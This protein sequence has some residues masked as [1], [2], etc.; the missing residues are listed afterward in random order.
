M[1]DLAC[2]V[3]LVWLEVW[4]QRE[5]VPFAAS[6]GTIYHVT[7]IIAQFRPEPIPSNPT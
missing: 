1:A 6:S 4:R 7:L 5:A 3:K 2:G